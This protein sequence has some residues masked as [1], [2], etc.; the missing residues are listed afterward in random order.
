MN[1]IEELGIP[2]PNCFKLIKGCMVCGEPVQYGDSFEEF[3]NHPEM[4]SKCKKAILYVRKQIGL[5]VQS[6]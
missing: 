2:D 5:E 4:C 1:G 6:E 3:S